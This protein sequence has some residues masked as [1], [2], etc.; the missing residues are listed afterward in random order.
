MHWVA[1]G[2]KTRTHR[3]TH[4]ARLYYD[5]AMS[6]WLGTALVLLVACSNSSKEAPRPCPE[7]TPEAAVKVFVTDRAGVKSV[8]K[9]R[10]HGTSPTSDDVRLLAAVCTNDRDEACLREC[11]ALL[12]P[13]DAGPPPP[14]SDAGLLP[15]GGRKTRTDVA[16]EL[17]ATD[18]ALVKA[19]L[20]PAVS[21]GTASDEDVKI[22]RASCQIMKDKGCLEYLR[23]K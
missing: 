9:A 14:A 6:R 8:L 21:A 5:G 13:P 1:A 16:R 4:L 15:D 18:P 2:R 19:M 23:N 22:L 10:V 17:V 11:Q 12:A 7:V 3:T 20:F